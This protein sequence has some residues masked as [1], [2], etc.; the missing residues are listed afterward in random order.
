MDVKQAFYFL[1]STTSDCVLSVVFAETSGGLFLLA[2]SLHAMLI[3]YYSGFLIKICSTKL[4]A[5]KYTT[6]T[7]ITFI[8][9]SVVSLK[10]KIP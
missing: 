3:F 4:Y 8:N 7:T 5:L 1:F 10:E 2:I 9:Q 6:W